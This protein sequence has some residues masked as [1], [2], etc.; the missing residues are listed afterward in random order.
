MQHRTNRSTFYIDLLV[1]FVVTQS[2]ET[3]PCTSITLRAVS[4]SASALGTDGSDPYRRRSEIEGKIDELLAGGVAAGDP[5]VCSQSSRSSGG[6]GACEHAE[7]RWGIR[8]EAEE[9]M[10]T[11]SPVDDQ[12]H[13][14]P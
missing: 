13:S 9:P 3:F 7:A 12:P 5:R 2:A 8:R 11:R 4:S 14:P 6:G 1:A 10:L